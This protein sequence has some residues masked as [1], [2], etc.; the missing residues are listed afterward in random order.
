LVA[1]R[2]ERSVVIVTRTD[3][4]EAVMKGSPWLARSNGRAALTHGSQRYAAHVEP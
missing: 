1:I 3:G 4:L 2:V